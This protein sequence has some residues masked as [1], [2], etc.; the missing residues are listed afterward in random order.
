MRRNEKYTAIAPV[1]YEAELPAIIKQIENGKGIQRLVWTNNKTLEKKCH[2]TGPE[3]SRIS[4]LDKMEALSGKRDILYKKDS[5][6]N[7]EDE[8]NEL[9]NIRRE[10]KRRVNSKPEK[11]YERV[12]WETWQIRLHQSPK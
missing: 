11:E 6:A 8:W 1:I 7:D 12:D 5:G 2:G 3:E 10:I 4:G 9:I